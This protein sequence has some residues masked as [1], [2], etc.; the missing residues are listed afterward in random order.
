LSHGDEFGATY[1]EK[2]LFR[3]GSNKIFFAPKIG[4]LFC[5]QFCDGHKSCD[6]PIW[7]S[8]NEGSERASQLQNEAC[9]LACQS[10]TF[11]NLPKSSK[12]LIKSSRPK[13]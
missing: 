9:G 13:L 7:F 10:E 3:A 8:K 11:P 12:L 6:F 1:G 4:L 2:M 5:V